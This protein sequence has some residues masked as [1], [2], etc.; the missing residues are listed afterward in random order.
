MRDHELI[1][2]FIGFWPTEKSLHG[3]IRAKWKPKGQVTLQ[4]RPKGFFTAI[5]NCLEDK[6]RVMDEGPY[7]FNSPCLY[8][9]DS[10]ERFNQNKE[11]F[12]WTLVSIRIY[13]L[14]LEYWDEESI[15]DI[16]NGL[17]EF[18]KIAQET[19]LRRYT[20]YA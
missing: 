1:G 11:D 16:G 7:F 18:S 15:K 6:N 2:K 5:F 17:A 4:L 20:S 12:S 8:L 13:S 14:S 10:I 9:R 19:K 3:C